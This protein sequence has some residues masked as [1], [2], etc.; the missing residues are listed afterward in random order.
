ISPNSKIYCVEEIPMSNP[1]IEE[2]IAIKN[3]KKP[4]PCSAVGSVSATH[5][6]GEQML[7]AVDNFLGRFVSYPSEHARTAHTLWCVHAHLIH[8]WES[9]P[10]LAFLSPEPASG[11][12]RAMEITN[13]LV[14]NPVLAVN[15]SPTYLFR[16]VAQGAVTLL[17]DEIDAVFGPKA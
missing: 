10:R 1:L 6:N 15:F 12:T 9:T 8:L 11:K 13:L 14:P 16:K 7:E 2:I 17:Y 5:A 4:E 3:G